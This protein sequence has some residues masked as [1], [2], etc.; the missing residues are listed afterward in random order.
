MVWFLEG[1]QHKKNPPHKK[2]QADI[3][4]RQRH[5]RFHSKVARLQSLNIISHT[6]DLPHTH[7]PGARA[8]R[9]KHT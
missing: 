9:T 2:T 5:T 4:T 8:R 7:P 3:P 1:A 6:N